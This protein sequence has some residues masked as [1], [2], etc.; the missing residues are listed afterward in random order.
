MLHSSLLKKLIL[1]LFSTPKAKTNLRKKIF[2]VIFFYGISFLF[3]LKI[4]VGIIQKSKSY[5]FFLDFLKQ[6]H[7]FFIA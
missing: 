2:I 7:A 5:I 4:L 6:I 1:A 3:L